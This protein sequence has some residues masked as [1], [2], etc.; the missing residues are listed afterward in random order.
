[1]FERIQEGPYRDQFGTFTNTPRLPDRS[2]FSDCCCCISHTSFISAVTEARDRKLILDG[3]PGR[4]KTVD[5]KGLAAVFALYNRH[6][7]LVLLNACFT[8]AQ[9]RAI[10]EVVDYSVGTGK[11]IGDKAGV[12]FAGEFYRRLGSADRSEKRLNQPKPNSV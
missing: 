12:A 4:G 2:I 5:Q 9:A 3:A 1:M 8:K 11:G 7:R 10:S 6:V